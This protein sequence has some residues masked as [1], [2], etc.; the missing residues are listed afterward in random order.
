[1]IVLLA[2]KSGRG[3][4]P[5]GQS[6]AA[7]NGGGS[8]GGATGQPAVPPSTTGA[9][10]SPVVASSA[11]V[12]AARSA[13][14]AAARVAMQ[15]ASDTA[16]PLSAV[17]QPEG[18]AA[19]NGSAAAPS[20]VRICIADHRTIVCTAAQPVSC[21]VHVMMPKSHTKALSAHALHN[22]LYCCLPEF[23]GTHT[24]TSSLST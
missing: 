7:T 8:G 19:K 22:E 15:L 20:K 12:D 11:D 24:A 21:S 4:G 1:M 6:R 23:S 2:G 17:G 13:A 9:E 14:Q 16:G 5:K 10:D 18:G 3:K